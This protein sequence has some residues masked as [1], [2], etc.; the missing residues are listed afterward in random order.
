[1]LHFA[2][3]VAGYHFALKQTESEVYHVISDL[4]VCLVLLKVLYK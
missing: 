3:T 2:M 4:T 1:M